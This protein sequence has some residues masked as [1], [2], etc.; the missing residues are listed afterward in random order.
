MIHNNKPFQDHFTTHIHAKLY[1]IILYCFLDS[2]NFGILFD[3]KINI[4]KI[5]IK[6]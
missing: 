1:G 3:K 2:S 4:N 5:V 6:R